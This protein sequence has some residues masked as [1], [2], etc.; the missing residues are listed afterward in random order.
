MLKSKVSIRGQTV[1]PQEIREKLG[2]KPNSEVAWWV[3]GKTITL[4]PLPENPV[5][6]SVGMFAD[7]GYT[8]EDF[9]KER[10]EEREQE[11]KRD[12][13]ARAKM[14]PGSRRPPGNAGKVRLRS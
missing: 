6:A 8:L 10:A 7:R 4:I 13:A 3:E 14:R 12:E 5:A 9:L 11:L 2:I 1:I